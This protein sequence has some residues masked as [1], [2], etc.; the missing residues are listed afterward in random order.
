MMIYRK[1]WCLNPKE[2]DDEGI[3]R[4]KFTQTMAT[5]VCDE[6]DIYTSSL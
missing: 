2:L 3:Q 6:C 1:Y 4:Q 5:Y